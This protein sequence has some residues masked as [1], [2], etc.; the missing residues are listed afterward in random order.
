MK[1]E[2]S[3]SLIGLL[4]EAI[5]TPTVGATVVAMFG[6]WTLATICHALIKSMANTKR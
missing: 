5:K 3:E 4:L 2:I 1:I 6:I